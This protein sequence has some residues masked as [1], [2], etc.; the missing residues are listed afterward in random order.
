MSWIW[1]GLLGL[2]GFLIVFRE[3]LRLG[4]SAISLPGRYS[5]VVILMFTLFLWDAL[6]SPL[7]AIRLGFPQVLALLMVL[8]GDAAWRAKTKD[9]MRSR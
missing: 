1:G 9:W 7:F 5:A 8:Q 3:A 2:C 4:W 6:F